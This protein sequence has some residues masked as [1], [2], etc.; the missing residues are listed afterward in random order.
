METTR[1]RRMS[2]CICQYC[3]RPFYASRFDAKFCSDK[4]RVYFHRFNKKFPMM[5][6]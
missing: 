3:F 5:D 4:H 1:R 6:K 2:R